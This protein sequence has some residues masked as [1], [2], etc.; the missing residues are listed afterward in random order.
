MMKRAVIAKPWA[1]CALAAAMLLSGRAVAEPSATD[2]SLA[3]SLFDE[4]KE[5]MRARQYETACPKFAESQRIDP[6]S[7]TLL[8]LA[9]CH[10]QQGKYASAWS[11][12]KD[13]LSDAKRDG[14]ADRAAGAE[15]HIAALKPKLPWLTLSVTTPVENLDVKLDGVSIGRA[16]WG[17][18][19][20]V[21]PGDHE[22]VA[23][24]P[25]YDR[26]KTTFASAPGAEQELS[27][28]TLERSP[29]QSAPPGAPE[30]SALPGNDS[31]RSSGG[32]KRTAG[33]VAIGTGAAALGVGAYFGVRSLSQRKE[34]D[35]L[36]PTD[37]TCTD[38]GVELNQQALTSAWIC[39]IGIG[40]GIA[41]VGLGTVLLL[42]DDGASKS[43]RV[44]TG[45]RNVAVT[46]RV[47]PGGA[48]VSVDGSF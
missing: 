1:P 23:E 37:T 16:A 36:C 28:P 15:E 12:F 25:G 40:L 20:A 30:S 44:F 41:G 45:P 31:S 9:L 26:W 47:L 18:R 11:E 8:N 33:W 5:L 4:G 14:R 43:S 17:T 35:K 10:E 24:A 32:A 27:V 22:L 39:N 48:G 21:D 7:G 2:K 19:L 34:S 29:E 46:T 6:S 42:T 3:Q 38:R 13:A